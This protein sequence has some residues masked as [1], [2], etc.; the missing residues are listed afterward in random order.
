M[1]GKHKYNAQKVTVDGFKFD[2]TK[3]SKRY[4]VLRD[5]QSAGMI[6]DLELQPRF[7]WSTTYKANGKSLTSN[8]FFYKAD[9]RYTDSE[10]NT[11]VEDVK[12]YRYG[13]AYQTFKRKRRI[14]E[15]LY[16]IRII[17]I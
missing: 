1:A 11:V 4:I 13:P 10:N 3:E 16:G 17:E 9:F 14:V 6:E 12:G 8:R 5:M 7:S 15:H 2:S